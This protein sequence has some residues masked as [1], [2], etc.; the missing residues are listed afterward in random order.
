[1]SQ[2]DLASQYEEVGKTKPFTRADLEKAY[3]PYGLKV[4]G[5][6]NAS[7]SD[8]YTTAARAVASFHRKQKA[9][10]KKPQAP[11]PAPAPA[12]PAASAARPPA[13]APSSQR[14]GRQLFDDAYV[15]RAM[16]TIGLAGVS[17]TSVPPEHRRSYADLVAYLNRVKAQRALAFQAGGGRGPTLIR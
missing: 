7:D 6:K 5:R 11:K 15:S 17:P 9:A 4:G 16:R 10:A 12:R 2:S 13:L 14:A 1:M 8:L 3:Q